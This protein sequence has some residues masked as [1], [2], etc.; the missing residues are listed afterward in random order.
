MRLVDKGSF[1][2]MKRPISSLDWRESAPNHLYGNHGFYDIT[3]FEEEPV[4][5]RVMRVRKPKT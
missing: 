5:I 2:E 1:L 3:R 4:L